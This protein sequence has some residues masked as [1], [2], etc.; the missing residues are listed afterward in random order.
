MASCLRFEAADQDLWT[1]DFAGNYHRLLNPGLFDF[2]EKRRAQPTAIMKDVRLWLVPVPVKGVYGRVLE[3]LKRHSRFQPPGKVIQFPYDW[4][5]DLVITA[6]LL[7]E[8]LRDELGSK[9]ERWDSRITPVTHSMGGLVVQIAI[10]NGDLPI[11]SIARIV[12]IAAPFKGSASAFKSLYDFVDF[13]LAEQLYRLRYGKN[14]R[15]AQQNLLKAMKTFPSVFQLLPPENQPFVYGGATGDFNPLGPTQTV[16]PAAMKAAAL[17]AHDAIGRSI[18][19]IRG[20][21][22]EVH[23]VRGVDLAKLTDERY[24][25]F[26]D[27]EDYKLVM[28]VPREAT[29]EG[30]GTVAGHSADYDGAF[31][32]GNFV[33]DV[34]GAQ[35][36]FMC[37]H[38]KVADIVGSRV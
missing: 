33:H 34:D 35:H 10:A 27:R 19:L 3:V 13:P 11:S 26:V 4:R 23:I 8:K 16:V 32:D 36:A 22:I 2:D 31:V 24:T 1:E 12:H 28:P 7:G 18:A 5:G 25:A 30:D 29:Q 20:R 38:P 21:E 37:N 6:K 9:P 15:R 14:K 17:Q